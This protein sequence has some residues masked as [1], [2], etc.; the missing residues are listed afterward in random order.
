MVIIF[1]KKVVFM[2][3][4]IICKTCNGEGSIPKILWKK[5]CPNCGGEGRI[6]TFSS[7]MIARESDNEVLG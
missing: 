7:N 3:L 5:T 2:A 6:T 4:K 1:D